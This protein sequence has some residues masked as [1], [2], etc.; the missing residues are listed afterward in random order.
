VEYGGGRL[1]SQVLDHTGNVVVYRDSTLTLTDSTLRH[2]SGLG[3]VVN[4]SNVSTSGNT[5]T[6]NADGDLV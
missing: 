6:N 4:N 3:L 1:F 2:S 5:F